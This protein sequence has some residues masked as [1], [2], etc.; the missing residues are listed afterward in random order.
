MKTLPKLLKCFITGAASLLT[1]WLITCLV[2]YRT[3]SGES[4]KVFVGEVHY[5]FLELDVN[6]RQLFEELLSNRVVRLIDQPLLFVSVDDRDK[7]WQESPH[8]MWKK[9]YTVVATLV[10]DPL[11]FG[12]YNVA[13]I[14]KLDFI[15]KKPV[16]GK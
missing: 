13:R 15:N 12:G 3:S 16:I 4:Q 9:E 8:E 7:L 2:V 5:K 14:V 10:A 6:N 1:L 11:Y